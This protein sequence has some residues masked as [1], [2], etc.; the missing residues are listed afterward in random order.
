MNYTVKY[1]ARLVANGYSKV[2][3]VDFN[4]IFAPMAKFTT[5]STVFAIRATMD[6]EMHQI[7]VKIA[8]FNRELEEGIYIKQ[9]QGFI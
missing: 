8:F 2:V 1:K 4:E 5:I 6:L 7:D 9:P 3:G